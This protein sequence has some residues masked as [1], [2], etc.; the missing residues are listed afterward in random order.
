VYRSSKVT[1]IIL[2]DGQENDGSRFILKKLGLDSDCPPGY[3]HIHMVEGF[4]PP[5]GKIYEVENC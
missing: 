1:N 4:P 3:S 5:S 2:M